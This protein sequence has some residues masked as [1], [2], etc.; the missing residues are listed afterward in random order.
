MP[1][2]M[3]I[4]K[5]TRIL[6]QIKAEVAARR[7]RCI[8]E[9]GELNS[10]L[11]ASLYPAEA[12]KGVSMGDWLAVQAKEAAKQ[13]LIIDDYMKGDSA[14]KDFDETVTLGNKPAARPKLFGTSSKYSLAD[15]VLETD[16]FNTLRLGHSKGMAFD[17]NISMKELFASDS[18]GADR[19]NVESIRTG[20]L[21]TL[22]RTRVTLLDVVPQLPTDQHVVKYDR[23]SV[24]DSAAY[25]L[26]QGD[27]YSES[28]FRINEAT[29]TVVK[30]GAFIQVSEELLADAPEMR[31]RLNGALAQQLLRRIQSDIVG[32][33][34]APASEYVSGPSDDTDVDGFLDLTNITEINFVSGNVGAM[35]GTFHNPFTVIQQGIEQVYRNGEAETNAIVM[36]SQDWVQVI[37]LQSTTGSFIAQG[38]G[39]G[40]ADPVRQEIGGIPVILCNALPNNTVILGDF[41][42]HAVLRDRQAVQVRIQEAQAVTLS[43]SPANTTVNTRPS[44]RYNIYVDARFAFYVRRGLAF[45]KIDNFGVPI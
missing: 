22:A 15:E 4:M 12:E 29:A 20:D 34:P 2:N 28:A 44:G 9:A 33:A 23:E 24:N 1:I 10:E 45:T 21:V 32:G 37:T 11:F 26:G 7:D 19:V 5:H 31:A 38:S 42:N 8:D 30:R 36:N 39:A 16:D 17:S 27:V 6:Q 41:T 25:E 14:L 3:N 18:D 13:Q 43:G 35:A 40:M